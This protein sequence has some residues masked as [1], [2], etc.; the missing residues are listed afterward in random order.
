MGHI[1]DDQLHLYPE[2]VLFLLESN[3]I[4]VSLNKVTMSLQQAYEVMFKTSSLIS[5]DEYRVYSQLVRQGYKI[6]RHQGDLGIT[7]YERKI[8]IDQYRSKIKK[9]RKLPNEEEVIKTRQIIAAEKAAKID[10]ILL[11]DDEPA[12]GEI[13][14]LKA[15]TG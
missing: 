5:L 12:A 7:C 3:S 14:F 8:K 2:E 11:D 9:K 10:E 13:L 4:E 6:V 15:S 1:R